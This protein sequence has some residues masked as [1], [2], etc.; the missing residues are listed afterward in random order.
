MSLAFLWAFFE[1]R[2]ISNENKK[3]CPS[4]IVVFEQ[5]R[6]QK[7]FCE[8]LN[9]VPRSSPDSEHESCIVETFFYFQFEKILLQEAKLR[10]PKSSPDQRSSHSLRLLKKDR[11]SIQSKQIVLQIVTTKYIGAWNFL[12]ISPLVEDKTMI[13]NGPEELFQPLYI[14]RGELGEPKIPEN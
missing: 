7:K 10:S 13:S 9:S 2:K 6:F 3:I 5:H 12:Y 4:Q 1:N 11:V 14:T 8:K